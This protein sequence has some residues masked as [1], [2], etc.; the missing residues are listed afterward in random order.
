[1]ETPMGTVSIVVAMA[2]AMVPDMAVAVGLAMAV[3]MA[4]DMVLAMAAA[5]VP[6]DHF[7]TEDAI[8]LAGRT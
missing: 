8:P 6:T 2:V 5:A 7:A 3:V 1:M 4:V